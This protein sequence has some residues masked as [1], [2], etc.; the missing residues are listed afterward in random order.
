MVKGGVTTTY[1]YGADGLR[2]QKTV[3]STVYNYY[4]SDGL[5]MR[6]TWGVNYI[7]FLYDESGLA[8]GFVYNGTKYYYV[9]NLQG[10]VMSIANADGGIVVNYVYDAWGNI[11]STTGSMASTVGAVNPI[12]Y[13]SYYYDTETGFYYLQSRYYDPAIRRFIN[14]DGYVNANGDILGFNM[15]AYC[16]NNPVMGYDPTGAGWWEDCID[17]VNNIIIQPV[18]DFVDE[19]IDYLTPPSQE[20][21]YNRNQNNI[22]FPEEYD[23][24]FF[25]GWD[26]G[27]SANCHQF[28]APN[29]DN[30]KYVSPDGRYEAIYDA[31]NKLVTDPRDV[32]TY[33]FVSPNEDSIGHFIK[34]VIPW[35]QHGNSENDTTTP[36]QRFFSFFGI[37]F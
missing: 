32:G 24:T 23:E 25:E 35:I 9:K 12:R 36:T 34:D 2:T 8:Y 10:D 1:K 6:Q 15:Y 22:Q 28:S 11:L 30:V 37:Y 7:D 21:H 19:V 5:L 33:N 27:V 31:N 16:G 13:R 18:T 26:D 3:G 17:W 14:A 29:K 20:D 4:Y